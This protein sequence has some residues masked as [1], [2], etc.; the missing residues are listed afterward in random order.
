MD[1]DT[2]VQI[3]VV[4]TSVP[5]ILQQAPA[6]VAEGQLR[7]PLPTPASPSRSSARHRSQS[8]PIARECRQSPEVSAFPF[9]LVTAHQT[10]PTD[11]AARQ[12]GPKAMQGDFRRTVKAHRNDAYSAPTEV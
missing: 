5:E 12:P 6:L 10:L 9:D 2:R 3:A 11:H 1:I 7:E 4:P 8:G